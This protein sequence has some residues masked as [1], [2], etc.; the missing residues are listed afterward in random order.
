MNT[1]FKIFE[2]LP[3]LFCILTRIN[4]YI[5]LQY[6][7]FRYGKD[8]GAYKPS[9]TSCLCGCLAPIIQNYK[10]LLAHIYS[11]NKTY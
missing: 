10:K 9:Y 6:T 7:S 8:D 2:Y 3:K 5:L 4:N 11:R 1:V